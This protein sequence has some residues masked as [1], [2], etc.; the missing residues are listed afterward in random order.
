MVDV[1]VVDVLEVVVEEEEVV[2]DSR[3]AAIVACGTSAALPLMS[4]NTAPPAKDTP[5]TTARILS[6]DGDT[7]GVRVKARQG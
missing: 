6:E 3:V 2:D 4:T 1:E 7:G 5:A